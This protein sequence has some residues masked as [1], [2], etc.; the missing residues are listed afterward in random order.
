MENR[1]SSYNTN[2]HAYYADG[3]TVSCVIKSNRAS[4]EKRS[5]L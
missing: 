1:L 3:M 2:I 5:M 4:A